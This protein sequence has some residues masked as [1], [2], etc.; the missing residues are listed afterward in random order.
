MVPMLNRN[1]RAKSLQSHKIFDCKKRANMI[2]IVKYGTYVKQGLN[3]F[4]HTRYL[5]VKKGQI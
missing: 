2:I 4:N 1:G 3:L 5:T